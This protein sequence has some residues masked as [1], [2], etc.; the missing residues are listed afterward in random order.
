MIFEDVPAYTWKPFL[1]LTFLSYAKRKFVCCVWLLTNGVFFSTLLE[2]CWSHFRDRQ[3]SLVETGAFPDF[4]KKIC[5]LVTQFE[6]FQRNRLG[7]P[8]A[9]KLFKRKTKQNKT[10][11]VV[12]ARVRGLAE[13]G[14]RLTTGT[15]AKMS[16]ALYSRRGHT[17]KEIIPAILA[18]RSLIVGNESFHL[19]LLLWGFMY[20]SFKTRRGADFIYGEEPLYHVCR[21]QQHAAFSSAT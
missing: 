5:R 12:F 10:S 1:F 17:Y 13:T 18:R 15:Y 3:I 7:P 2:F 21:L 19:T 20:V 9:E 14:P 11:K 4:R 6:R 8:I 16:F